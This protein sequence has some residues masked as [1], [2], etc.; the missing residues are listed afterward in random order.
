MCVLIV[1][2]KI[3]GNGP[4]YIGLRD[5]YRGLEGIVSKLLNLGKVSK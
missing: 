5:F 2:D 4:N 3:G 1:R